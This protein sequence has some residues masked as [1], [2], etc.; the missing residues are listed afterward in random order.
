MMH[1]EGAVEIAGL[2]DLILQYAHAAR[3]EG[4]ALGAD[5]T[6]AKLD[7]AKAVTDKLMDRA[8]R[9]VRRLEVLS[10]M[11]GIEPSDVRA[12]LIGTWRT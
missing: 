12:A 2:E 4:F 9:R 7:Q 1:A 11:G 10:R 8:L 3:K 6:G 5:G